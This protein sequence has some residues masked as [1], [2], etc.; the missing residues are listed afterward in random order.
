LNVLADL[1]M[2]DQQVMPPASPPLV[3]EDNRPGAGHMQVNHPS[4]CEGF[5]EPAVELGQQVEAGALLGTV[6]DLLGSRCE[7]VR[8]SCGAVTTSR[9]PCSETS[10]IETSRLRPMPSELP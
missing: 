4:P 7:E 2:V 6:T 1:D 9:A 8:A 3:V 5:F 10:R